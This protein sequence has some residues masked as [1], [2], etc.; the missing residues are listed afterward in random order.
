MNLKPLFFFQFLGFLFSKENSVWDEKYSEISNLDMNNPLSH[1]WINS[2]HNT[3]VWLRTS[4]QTTRV[5]TTLNQCHT[6]YLI[7][8]IF[9]FY[10]VIC[11]LYV[12]VTLLAVTLLSHI[13]VILLCLILFIAAVLCMF[14]V[15]LGRKP[16]KKSIKK[17]F[18][19]KR[20]NSVKT[21][22]RPMKINP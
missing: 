19:I 21:A 10:V 6:V 18:R 22:L 17:T 3:S 15:T 8:V 16:L 9:C 20:M 2:S 1:Y 7:L 4:L 13:P 11:Y 14:V 5:I 12:A